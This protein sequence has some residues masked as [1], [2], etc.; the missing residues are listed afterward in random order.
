MNTDTGRPEDGSPDGDEPETPKISAVPEAPAADQPSPPTSLKR[1]RPAG[2]DISAALG[3]SSLYRS[4]IERIMG[5]FRQIDQISAIS[6]ISKIF[7]SPANILSEINPAW[8]GMGDAMRH[9]T[10]TPVL[11]A[12]L[13]SGAASAS[14]AHLFDQPGWA[15]SVLSQSLLASYRPTILDLS[16]HIEAVMPRF[17]VVLP[18]IGRSLGLANEAWALVT[19]LAPETPDIDW[20]WRL[21]EAG[22]TTLG[23]T[24]T[25]L[26]L[27]PT[28]DPDWEDDDLVDDTD[29]ELIAGPEEARARLREELRRLD[30]RLVNRLEGAW[31]R[32]GRHGPDAVSQAANSLVELLDR[33]LHLAAP[34]GPVL[35]WHSDEDRPG[36]ELHHGR[37]TRSLRVRF[38]LRARPDAAAAEMYAKGL[39]ELMKLLQGHKHGAGEQQVGALTRLLPTVEAYLSFLLL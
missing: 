13:N 26:L 27:T 10:S 7:P 34:D 21:L 12:A 38:V 1:S 25:G 22:R 6:D 3:F 31:E 29:D 5:T 19:R 36:N 39:A 17:G 4:E 30:P 14:L 15:Q 33:T 9:I 11:N 35:A 28:G 20:T 24:A 32:V 16:A 23:V 18:Q 37:P 8:L 2:R